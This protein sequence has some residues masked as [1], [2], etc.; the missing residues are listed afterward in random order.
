MTPEEYA[1]NAHDRAQTRRELEQAMAEAVLFVIERNA[2]G[3]SGA[4][5]HSKVADAL[6]RYRKCRGIG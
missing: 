2:K 5:F 4:R 6:S 3:P 1:Q